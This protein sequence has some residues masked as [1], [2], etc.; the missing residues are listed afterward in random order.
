[1]QELNSTSQFEVMWA[2]QFL[3]RVIV[4]LEGGPQAFIAA[5]GP[6]AI[7][8]LNTAISSNFFRIH[9]LDGSQPYIWGDAAEVLSKYPETA[10]HHLL[11]VL[12]L[13]GNSPSQFLAS[14]SFLSETK[15]SKKRRNMPVLENELK[16]VSRRSSRSGV[17]LKLSN[18][19][20]P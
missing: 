5:Q 11:A 10:Q 3:A 2:V 14:Q 13:R 7:L 6:D 16:T 9:S 1:M 17:G 18:R 15:K 12:E 19:R 4:N 8:A 20:K